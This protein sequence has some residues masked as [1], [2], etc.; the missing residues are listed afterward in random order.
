MVGLA[1]AA[2]M[3]VHLTG[4]RSGQSKVL[5]SLLIGFASLMLA[6]IWLLFGSRLPWMTRL[7]GLLLIVVAGIAFGFLFEIKGVTGNLL[8]ILGWRFGDASATDSEVGRESSGDLRGVLS[9]DDLSYPAF[10]G[11][12]GNATLQEQGTDLVDDRGSMP[13]QA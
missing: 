8:P 2:L 11:P 9:I 1:V 5:L 10:L 13:N 4:D 3:A 6:V 12:D 7:K